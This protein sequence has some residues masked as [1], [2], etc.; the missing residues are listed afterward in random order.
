MIGLG[1]SMLCV[2]VHAEREIVILIVLVMGKQVSLAIADSTIRILAHSVEAFV[3][4]A[5]PGKNRACYV[6][7]HSS[8]FWQDWLLIYRQEKS[9][10]FSS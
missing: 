7:H 4:R 6:I 8:S 9:S 1:F 10:G 3:P 2:R 5:V